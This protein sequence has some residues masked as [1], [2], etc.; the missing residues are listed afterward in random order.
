MLT[1]EGAGFHP[2]ALLHLKP[3]NA[4][5]LTASIGSLCPSLTVNSGFCYTILFRV[6]QG[7]LGNTPA[8]VEE[9]KT[10]PVGFFRHGDYIRS[11]HFNFE[12]PYV[13][14]PRRVAKC[15]RLPQEI[16]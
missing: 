8:H 14:C 3:D 6:N 9:R 16:Y 13:I 2:V 12:R 7:Q 10:R 15:K 11:G 4:L 5:D 1:T